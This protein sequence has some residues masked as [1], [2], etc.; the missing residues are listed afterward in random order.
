ME[1]INY[2]PQ[3]GQIERLT[4]DRIVKLFCDKL[5]YR[6]LGNWKD[7]QK[8][9]NIEENL[10]KKYLQGTGKYSDRLISKA[11]GELKKTA[12][13]QQSTL[14]EINKEIY[15][16]L[17][18]GISLHEEPGEPSQKLHFIDWD[19]PENNQFAVAE[20]VTIKGQRN[21]R[22]DI[23]LYINGIAVG[24]LELK[25][26]TVAVSEGIRQN[27][28]NQTDNYIKPFFTTVQLMIAGNDTEGLRYA[29]TETKE[30][31]YLSWSPKDPL[32][33]DEPNLLDRQLMQ[34]CN[35]ERLLE[36]IHDFIIFDSGIKKI[37]RHNQYFGVKAA[38]ENA[39]KREGGIIWHTQGSGKSLTMVWL[40]NWIR[41]NI[42]DARVIL[43][44]DRIE[45]DQ[46]IEGVFLG[47]NAKIYRT[48][49][50]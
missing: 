37:C 22:P 26:S 3:V 11:I 45:L 10:L 21:K 31:Y 36:I 29:T 46:Q 40:A 12:G 24:V 33:A 48:K 42:T 49:N 13:N 27:I 16:R 8:N 2:A 15:E 18:Y 6:Y 34:L 20:E 30:D 1:I 14:Y 38:Q 19:Y 4:Q 41:E 50:S 23:V 43:L 47:V 32:F 9:S 39:R 17:R 35:K 25:R 5:H 28:G 7:R 44:T